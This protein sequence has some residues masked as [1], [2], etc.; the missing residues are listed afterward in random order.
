MT[1]NGLSH[2]CSHIEELAEHRGNCRRLARSTLPDG[3]LAHTAFDKAVCRQPSQ[4]PSA[5]FDPPQTFTLITMAIVTAQ[6]LTAF[7]G[8]VM[9]LC[10]AASAR[11]YRLPNGIPIPPAGPAILQIV[12]PV[13]VEA[14]RRKRLI[15]AYRHRHFQVCLAQIMI[16]CVMDS[17]S[18]LPYSAQNHR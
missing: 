3:R 2:T 8:V 17:N 6:C 5:D 12:T 11:A 1:R 10:H 15:L 14:H 9:S 4:A 7:T 18:N 13:T 16:D